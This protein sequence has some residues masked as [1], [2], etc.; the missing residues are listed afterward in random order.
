MTMTM[1][2]G[3]KTDDDDDECCKTISFEV[4]KAAIRVS[5]NCEQHEAA[6]LASA[7]LLLLLLLCCCSAAALLLAKSHLQ[8]VC[9]LNNATAYKLKTQYFAAASATPSKVA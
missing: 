8:A 7:A 5:G 9:K 2:V 3:G 4:S 1:I 6:K